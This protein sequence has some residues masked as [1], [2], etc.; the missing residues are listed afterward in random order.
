MGHRIQRTSLVLAISLLILLMA[1]C[2][3]SANLVVGSPGTGPGQYEK[4]QG[5]A[6]DTSSGHVYVADTEND[7]VDVFDESGAFLFA[8]GS[9]GS[10]VGQFSHPGSIAVDSTSHDVY[11]VDGDNNR[12][13]KFDPAGNF[14]LAFGKEV[15]AGTSGNT[16]VCTNAGPPTDVCQAGTQGSSSGQIAEPPGGSRIGIG[17]SGTVYVFGDV[18]RLQKFDSSGALISTFALSP[19]GLGQNVNGFAV[20]SAGNFYTASAG[21]TGAVRKYDPAGNLLSTIDPSFNIHAL[22]LDPA[23]DLFVADITRSKK[24][25]LEY[26]ST[27]VKSRV[28]F[29][30]GMPAEF[31]IA[32]AFRHTSEGDLY[33]VEGFPGLPTARG[34]V[35]QL[36]LPEPGPLL[37]P[38]SVKASPVGNVKATLKVEFN[39]ENKASKAHFQYIAKTVYEA[40]LAEAKEGFDGAAETPDSAL[41]SADFENHTAEATNTCVVPTEAT[42]LKPQTTYYVRAIASN[43]D[44]TVSGEIAE[45]STLSP[46]EINSIWA[47]EVG[48]DIARLQA[49]V[50]PLAIHASAQFQYVDDATYQADLPNGF[51]HAKTTIGTLDFGAGETSLVRA[52]QAYPLQPGTTYHY[53]LVAEDP[54]FP[55]V[56][57]EAH[58]FT[59][60]SPPV[61]NTESC[62]ENQ[63]FRT[64]PSAALPDC[65]AFEL[66]T[67][68]DK[69][70]GDV[71]TRL[72]L[73]GFQTKLDQSSTVGSAFTYS[74]YRAF[75][76][77]QSAPYANQFLAT[78]HER[79]QAG[80]GWQNESIDPQRGGPGFFFNELENEYKA[81]SPDLSSGWLL[82]ETEPTFDPCAPAGFAG[83]Y[84]RDSTDGALAALSCAQPHLESSMFVPELEGFSVDGSHAVFRVDDPLTV[85]EG[86]TA[87]GATNN[88]SGG[89]RPIYQTYESSGAGQ[90]HLVSVLPNGEASSIDSSVGTGFRNETH[91]HNRYQVV[92]GAVSEDGTRVF[93]STGTGAT[94]PIYLRINA[95]QK[96]SNIVTGKCTQAAKACTIPVSET[97]TSEPALYQAANPQG[98]KALFTVT[99][100]PLKG[101]LYEF[102]S[103]PPAS[104]LIATM[105]RENILGASQDLSRVYFASEEATPEQQVEGALNGQPNIYFYD[106]GTTRFIGTLSS[107]GENS[108]LNSLFGSPI[109]ISPIVFRTAEVSADGASLVFMSNS[110]KLSEQTAE[111]DNTD[112]NSG[113]PDTEVYLYDATAREGKGKL[114]CISCNPT[115]ARPTGREIEGGINGHIG[116]WGAATVPRPETQLYQPRYLSDDGERVFFNSFDA[117]VV[118]DTNGAEDVYE[119]EAS[120]EGKCSE[121][122]ATYSPVSEGCLSLISSGQNPSDSEFFDSNSRGSDVFFTTAEGL[123]PQDYGLIDVYDAREGGGFPPPPNPTP[124]CEG[125][126]CQGPPEAPNDPTPAS[127]SGEYAGNVKEK[128]TSARCAKSKTS[129]KGRCVATKHK[130]K[131]SHNRRAGHN[132]G[133]GR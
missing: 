47:T 4:P 22:A 118:G 12:I 74:S 18:N 39:S 82:Q 73:T 83:L 95:D 123:L 80:E 130:S 131:K 93:W 27:G 60:F 52:V 1:T 6:V 116:P 62:V 133:T 100:G 16:D 127:S 30:D 132:R 37:V 42:C 20:D 107:G 120:G 78:R 17:P 121:E 114:R 14:L 58:T 34:R 69:S 66:V 26:N 126:A 43:A 13:E 71:I 57:S 33:A 119:W 46:L 19:A 59:T 35:V 8:F 63:A 36:A 9:I 40:N 87:S 75:S 109:A 28:F 48:T 98:T 77:P 85:S 70:N 56:D 65:R 128:P 10:G 38:G 117:L 90:L 64:G 15:N 94:G 72:N 68:L 99:Q 25:V 55:S 67:P 2:Q 105:V 96:Q 125:E 91:N 3:A 21:E 50:N 54:Y 108:D 81:F 49:E 84:R 115:G 97:V 106:D 5:V 124:S 7:R 110:K 45:F 31:P 104:H 86:P 11:V 53:R 113:R 111:Y 76:N 92:P 41:T 79:G 24:E 44:G 88:E 23:G 129:R 89:I 29:S 101:D 61:A 51:E 122:S 112:A 102:E 103:E 32:F